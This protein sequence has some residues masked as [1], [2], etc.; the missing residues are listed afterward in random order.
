MPTFQPGQSL[1][2]Q[3]CLSVEVLFGFSLLLFGLRQTFQFPVYLEVRVLF[4]P[5]QGEL[6]GVSPRNMVGTS[7]GM[8]P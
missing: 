5:F 8:K 2:P 7:I 3:S 6:H 1:G 4:Q